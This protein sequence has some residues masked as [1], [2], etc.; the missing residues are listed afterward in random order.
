M[1]SCAYVHRIITLLF[2]QFAAQVLTLF[3]NVIMKQRR[4]TEAGT[5]QLLLDVYSIKT[6]LLQLHRYA[7]SHHAQN[8]SC[9]RMCVTCA[10]LAELGWMR[11]PSMTTTRALVY[12]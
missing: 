11:L 4:I 8:V 6:I 3:T 10:S 1:V 9:D 7:R 12:R 5:Q 2:F